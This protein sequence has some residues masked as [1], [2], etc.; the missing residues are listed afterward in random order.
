MKIYLFNIFIFWVKISNLSLLE[1]ENGKFKIFLIHSIFLNIDNIKIF[2]QE[3]AKGDKIFIINIRKLLM[4]TKFS[5]IFYQFYEF[6]KDEERVF[7]S[8]YNFGTLFFHNISKFNWK[9]KVSFYL[10]AFEVRWKKLSLKENSSPVYFKE[11]CWASF[12]NSNAKLSI[13]RKG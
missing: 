12:L 7:L 4:F 11:T 6:T 9:V 1:K 5:D 13:E 2:N 3:G 8:S 10:K